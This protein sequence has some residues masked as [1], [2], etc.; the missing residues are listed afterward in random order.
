MFGGKDR[1]ERWRTKKEPRSREQR[2]PEWRFWEEVLTARD[3]LLSAEMALAQTMVNLDEDEDLLRQW[4][5]ERHAKVEE[6]RLEIQ[7]MLDELFR[8]VPPFG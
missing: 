5:A 4:A 3:Q 7:A 6:V 8:N 2:T 1:F